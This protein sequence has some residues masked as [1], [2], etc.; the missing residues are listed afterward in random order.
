M[1]TNGEE[2]RPGSLL[3]VGD[4]VWRITSN[5][6]PLSPSDIPHIWPDFMK[7]GARRVD[8]VS[9]EDS[10]VEAHTILPGF[11]PYEWVGRREFEIVATP[12]DEGHFPTCHE[13]GQPWPCREQIDAMRI[14]AEV[15]EA[16][17]KIEKVESESNHFWGC[18]WCARFQGLLK[19]FETKQVLDYHIA[20]CGSNPHNWDLDKCVPYF[21]SDLKV[22]G[23]FQP[24]GHKGMMEIL[25][26]LGV[27]VSR[28]PE[29]CRAIA[30]R[31]RDAVVKGKLPRTLEELI[32]QQE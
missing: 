13:C 21:N 28:D 18:Q 30:E 15:E 16:L 27:G 11:V 29:E 3:R 17:K 1:R 6:E 22:I 5:E 26:G 24:E 2:Y 31:V 9:L 8:L 25:N 23:A 12:D 19:R 20:Q 7:Q 4:H 32:N 10:A 14:R